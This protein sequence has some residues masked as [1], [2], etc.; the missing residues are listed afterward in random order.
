MI[1]FLNDTVFLLPWPWP[2]VVIVLF[3]LLFAVFAYLKRSLSAS[4]AL[5]AFVMGV[6]TLWTVRFEG[7]LLFLLFFLSCNIV[8]K[9]SKRIRSVWEPVDRSVE[10]KGSRRDAMQVLANGLMTVLAAL[11]WYYTGKASALVMF[12]A[13]VAEATSDTFAGEVGRL[14]KRDPV[15][16]LTMKPIEKGLSGG[17][18]LLGTAA[19][20]FSSLAIA[21]CWYLWFKTSIAQTAIVCILGFAGSVV[22]SFLG[23][24]VQAM[25]R[26]PDTGK[27]TEHDTKNGQSLELVRGIRWMDNDMVNL[28]SNVFSAVF[29]LGMSAMVL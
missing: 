8:G 26:D 29:A 18:T 6:V 3:M 12:G 1:S 17:V 24:F 25:Y 19:A 20:F 13:A 11:L 15:S 27:L 10:K 16:I 9:I 2:L 4:G 21:S 28:M 5:G 22:D 14:S 23:A 7:F